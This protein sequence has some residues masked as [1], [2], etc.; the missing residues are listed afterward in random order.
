MFDA[1]LAYKKSQ[2]EQKYVPHIRL[3][4]IDSNSVYL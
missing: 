4:Y 1:F 2:N 3:I